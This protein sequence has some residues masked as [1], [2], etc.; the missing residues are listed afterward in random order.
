MASLKTPLNTCR[1]AERRRLPRGVM[2]VV[3]VPSG[4]QQSH[5]NN[6]SAC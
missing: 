2:V 5:N 6:H 3:G 4:R 1:S